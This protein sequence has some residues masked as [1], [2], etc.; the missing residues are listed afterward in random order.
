ME[1]QPTISELRSF[2]KKK[3]QQL[4]NWYTFRVVGGLVSIWF[5]FLI[6]PI[7]YSMSLAVRPLDGVR[8]GNVIVF[9]AVL[10]ASSLGLFLETE[11]AFKWRLANYHFIGL[12]FVLLISAVHIP[13]FTLPQSKDAPK[14]VVY[15]ISV[16]L[17]LTVVWL[18]RNTFLM[19]LLDQESLNEEDERKASDSMEKAKHISK[20]GDID[21]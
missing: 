11:R 15:G 16:V 20:A 3:K 10:S 4:I 5:G 9:V 7:C 14:G 12:I 6:W 1:Y 18:A 13:F 17:L 8:N 19:R 2:R 21:I